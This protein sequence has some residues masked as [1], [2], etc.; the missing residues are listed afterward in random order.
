MTDTLTHLINSWEL[1]EENGRFIAKADQIIIKN[2]GS[3]NFSSGDIKFNFNLKPFPWWGNIS[4]PKIIVLALNP[5]Y[6][7]NEKDKYEQE[8]HKSNCSFEK[9]LRNSPTINWLDFNEKEGLTVSQKWWKETFNDI[10]DE[11]IKKH[12]SKNLIYE[13]I[14]VFELFGYYSKSL[15]NYDSL[16]KIVNAEF[17]SAE[18]LQTQIA[19]FD[20]LNFLLK[21]ETPPLVVVIWG[22][23]YWKYKIE[24]LCRAG[25]EPGIDYIDTINTASHALSKNNLRDID[26]KRI[27]QKLVE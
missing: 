12:K 5:K 15:N 26:F 22:Q 7:K 27:I 1:L 11:L 24:G 13:N 16:E 17:K 9:N 14:G 23:K 4:E 2:I 21:K 3:E 8:K 6:E 19:L 20:H 18:I 10:I 25:D